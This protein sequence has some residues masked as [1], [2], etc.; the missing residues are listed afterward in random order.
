MLLGRCEREEDD[1]EDAYVSCD[2][3]WASAFSNGIKDG[4]KRAEWGIHLRSSSLLLGYLLCSRTPLAAALNRLHPAT[5]CVSLLTR[6]SLAADDN[7][8]TVNTVCRGARYAVRH[9][10]HRA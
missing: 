8:D 7:F 6:L 2:V 5:R 3:A 9:F 1:W 4:L 10:D